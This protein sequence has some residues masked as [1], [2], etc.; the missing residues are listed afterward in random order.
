MDKIKFCRQGQ[1]V[2]VEIWGGAT[3]DGDASAETE[4]L[5]RKEAHARR[6]LCSPVND[7]RDES[8]L[9]DFIHSLNRRLIALET[10]QAPSP[11]MLPFKETPVMPRETRDMNPDHD[12][13]LAVRESPGDM[14][15]IGRDLIV[16][17]DAG[18]DAAGCE[19]LIDA[20]DLDIVD[21]LGFADNLYVLRSRDRIDGASRSFQMTQL[22]RQSGNDLSD[23][24]VYAEPVVVKN[25]DPRNKP[26]DPRYRAQWQW[27]NDRS[28]RYSHPDSDVEAQAAWE[29]STGQ[30]TC[31]AVID[32]GFHPF[33]PDLHDNIDQELSGSIAKNGRISHDL[34]AMDEFSHGSFCA[35][36]AAAVGNDRVGTCGIAYDAKLMLISVGEHDHVSQLDLARAIA[37]AADPSVMGADYAG[38][39]GA[40]ALTCAE[41]PASG[42]AKLDSVLKDA[43]DFAAAR[44]REGKGMPVFWAVANEFMDMRHDEIVSYD[45]VV[46][47][48]SSSKRAKV[49]GTCAY[50]DKLAFLAPGQNVYNLRGSGDTYGPDSGTSFAAPV[51][52]GIAALMYAVNPDLNAGDVVRMMKEEGCRK[53]RSMSDDGPD[54]RHG[55]G[56]LS[57]RACVEAVG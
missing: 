29:K 45:K 30:G 50:G 35:A 49:A 11:D 42:Y 12:L 24:I 6:C 22:S 44:G 1:D 25:Y 39:K 8:L 48:G 10:K 17:F 31:I 57:A 40:D 34:R 37:F 2:E 55:H 4:R 32:R 27:N 20:H 54:R 5:E 51:A 47:V 16:R 53:L 33:D 36:Q 13:Q 43:L 14:G 23:R 38:K 46:A 52:A 26:N 18:M 19:A 21:R 28:T 3:D 56:L 15:L 41:G 9:L 7:A